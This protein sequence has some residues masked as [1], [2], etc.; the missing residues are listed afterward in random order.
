MG[1]GAEDNNRVT[2]NGTAL[3]DTTVLQDRMYYE[4]D[5]I[6]TDGAHTATAM[7]GRAHTHVI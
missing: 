7:H 6:K 4:V 1:G 5:I 3:C 2:G